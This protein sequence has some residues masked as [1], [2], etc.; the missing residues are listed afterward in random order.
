MESCDLQIGTQSKQKM[1]SW[2]PLRLWKALR[3]TTRRVYVYCCLMLI[4]GK[5]IT[6][7]CDCKEAASCFADVCEKA[8]ESRLSCACARELCSTPLHVTCWTFFFFFFQIKPKLW[9]F[10]QRPSFFSEIETN[11]PWVYNLKKGLDTMKT[12]IKAECNDLQWYF[13]LWLINL[14]VFFCNY[15]VIRNLIP[16]TCKVMIFPEHEKCTGTA[17]KLF[18]HICTYVF[19]KPR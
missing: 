12:Q 17:P 11:V 9:K 16:A 5:N 7:H 13:I 4:S 6:E 15:T 14:I 2:K 3:K 18:G 1:H 19:L 10:T 8:N